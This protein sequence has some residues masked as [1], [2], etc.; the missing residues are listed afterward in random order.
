[1]CD[2]V[3]D[4]SSILSNISSTLTTFPSSLTSVPSS[5]SSSR[6]HYHQHPL[7][8]HYCPLLSITSIPS[9]L[10]TVPSSLFPASRPHSLLFRS[11]PSL[12]HTYS[13]VF[14]FPH[15]EDLSEHLQFRRLTALPTKVTES[16]KRDEKWPQKIPLVLVG[17]HYDI[18]QQSKTQEEIDKVLAALNA[19]A[20][21]LRTLFWPFLDIFP[22]VVP[23][24]CLKAR[25]EDMQRLKSTLDNIRLSG[26]R[27]C[28]HVCA[29]CGYVCVCTV[30][31]LYKVTGYNITLSTTTHMLGTVS[32]VSVQNVLITTTTCYNSTKQGDQWC[33]YKQF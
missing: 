32:L 10:T 24:N 14:L 7:L 23:I 25:G 33:C 5:P 13:F 31:S 16:E 30:K 12:S 20:D 26:V 18:L 17:S 21:G 15:R 28:I 6:P 3:I 9:S 4:F 29:V 19:M 22:Q 2:N 11:T 1:M 27:V 8:T